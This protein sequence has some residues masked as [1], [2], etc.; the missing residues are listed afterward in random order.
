VIVAIRRAPIAPHPERLAP[1][2]VSRNVKA[3]TR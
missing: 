3:L 1:G 2:D